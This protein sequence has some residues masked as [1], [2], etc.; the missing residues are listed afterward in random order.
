MVPVD[1]FM[2]SNN[3]LTDLYHDDDIQPNDMDSDSLR[4]F[5]VREKEVNVDENI[6]RRR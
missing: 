6:C 2:D 1:Y 4:A 5:L 3:S